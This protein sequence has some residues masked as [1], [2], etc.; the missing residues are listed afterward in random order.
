M[1][2]SRKEPRAAE[3]SSRKAERRQLAAAAPAVGF[4]PH[5][6]NF[7]HGL[8]TK[9]LILKGEDPVGTR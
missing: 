6:H 8:Y 4:V 2:L 3:R 1:S 7:K 5:E 9:Q